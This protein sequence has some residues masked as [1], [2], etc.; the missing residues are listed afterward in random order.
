MTRA[1][2]SKSV[3]YNRRVELEGIDSNLMVIDM[4]GVKPSRLMFPVSADLYISRVG[5]PS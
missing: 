2:I 3:K 1:Y 5:A 4:I